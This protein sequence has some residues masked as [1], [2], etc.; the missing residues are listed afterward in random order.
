MKIHYHRNPFKSKI[1]LTSI[2]KKEL[3][4]KLTI[5]RLHSM[6]DMASAYLSRSRPR[7]FNPEKAL[8]SVNIQYRSANGELP[9]QFDLQCQQEFDEMLKAL[10]GE[11]L[12]DCVQVA[13]SCTKCEAES[14]LG[15]NTL[16][17]MHQKTGGLLFEAFRL[18]NE[19]D[20]HDDPERA[21]SYLQDLRNKSI[22]NTS[23]VDAA[24][25]WLTAYRILYCN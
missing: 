14:L 20:S 18:E 17:N 2:E 6:M 25:R 4:Y 22:D 13:C 12:G 19:E 3:L 5:K 9:S 15:I 1:T 7:L 24:I 10:S 21:M 11:H 8:N 16:P 23:E